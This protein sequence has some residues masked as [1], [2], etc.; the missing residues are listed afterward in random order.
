M[1]RPISDCRHG[2]RAR[3]G[4]CRTGAL[5]GEAIVR[6]VV[7]G[8]AAERPLLELRTEWLG[9][10]RSSCRGHRSWLRG[11]R[12]GGLH[13]SKRARGAGRVASRWTRTT[14]SSIALVVSYSVVTSRSWTPRVHRRE[15]RL[16]HSL[17]AHR[18]RPP[19]DHLLRHAR[20]PLRGTPRSSRREE[21]AL[22]DDLV[23]APASRRLH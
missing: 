8:C 23:K 10:V 1:S 9:Q 4:E 11:P 7:A 2:R 20:L 12:P 21:K 16:H 5:D 15:P 14:A 13:P 6:V 22:L 17:P 18:A 19:Q 3:G